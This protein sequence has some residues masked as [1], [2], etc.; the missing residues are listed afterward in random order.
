MVSSAHCV[1][2]VAQC[3]AIPRQDGNVI[4]ITTERIRCAE[5][6]FQPSLAGKSD[7]GVHEV[8]FQAIVGPEFRGPAKDAAWTNCASLLI[9]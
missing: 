1:L 4:T 6:L 8:L 7:R 3:F 2:I 5:V 9:E